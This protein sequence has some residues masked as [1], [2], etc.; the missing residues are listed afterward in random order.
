[1]M[2][3]GDGPEWP[4]SAC[5]L[6]NRPALRLCELCGTP[7]VRARANLPVTTALC[8]SQLQQN[9]HQLQMAEK[10]LNN[11]AA[12]CLSPFPPASESGE[13]PVADIQQHHVPIFAQPWPPAYLALHWVMR[14]PARLA[15]TALGAFGICH[16]GPCYSGLCLRGG[17]GDL[18]STR[19][20]SLC[21]WQRPA[22]RHQEA[23]APAP[24]MA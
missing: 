19:R 24:E 3:D 20:P 2:S 23:A 15:H 5:T 14:L 21:I 8:R 17:W 10:Q 18:Y 16:N 11:D 22:G 4:C 12:L 6:L 13:T 1:M 9:T 7:K